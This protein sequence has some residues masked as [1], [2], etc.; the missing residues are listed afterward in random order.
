MSS[1]AQLAYQSLTDHPNLDTPE[2]IANGPYGIE[3]LDVPEISEGLRELEAGG[4]ARESSVGTW[5]LVEA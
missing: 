1:A 4:V 5:S 3:Q 2:A